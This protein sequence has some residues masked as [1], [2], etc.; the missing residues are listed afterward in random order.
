MLGRILTFN[1]QELQKTFMFDIITNEH[2][3]YW[4][5]ETE[6]H[7]NSGSNSQAPKKSTGN[8]NYIALY[9]QPVSQ[10]PH[11][12]PSTSSVALD[13]KEEYVQRDKEKTQALQKTI[14]EWTKMQQSSRPSKDA[15]L[16][17]ACC[18][19]QSDE[20]DV[21]CTGWLE[22][23]PPQKKLGHYAWKK[24]W[25]ILWIYSK[26]CG[27]PDVLEYYENKHSM[28][29]LGI[30]NL[31]FC[32][33]LDI[34]LT[35]NKKELHKRFMFDIIIKE[36]TFYLVAETDADR[37]RPPRGTAIAPP[38]HPK[39]PCGGSPQQR[40]P[41]SD[42]KYPTRGE[43][44][45]C[46]S[47]KSLEKTTVGPSDSDSSDFNYM[48]SFVIK[49]WSTFNH[50]FNPSSS[51]YCRSISN[52]DSEDSEENCV[53]MQNPMSPSPVPSGTNNPAPKKS[54]GNANSIVLDFQ[55]LSPRPHHKPSTSLSHQMKKE[56]MF[57]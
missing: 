50:T 32:T 30:I 34:A 3:F 41:V 1:K 35:F 51:Q 44:T 7:M 29:P 37:N 38:P 56:N 31:N 40:P 19:L 24:C 49:S 4:V 27:D 14:Q 25:F 16:C 46:L 21:V 45:A 9:F 52:T 42:Y 5:A 36:S 55:A 47:A 33:Q 12:K 13:E 17:G 54:T 48:P 6:A 8:V 22:K 18:G 53:P 11:R 57:K 20:T 23:S 43:E 15:K 39:T 28:K 2:T 26:M 10:S